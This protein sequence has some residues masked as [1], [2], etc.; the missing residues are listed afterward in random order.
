MNM[1]QILVLTIVTLWN[2]AK[3]FAFP[4]NGDEANSPL[5]IQESG[6]DLPN[7]LVSPSKSAPPASSFGRA[8]TPNETKKESDGKGIQKYLDISVES[9]NTS[10][11]HSDLWATQITE[12]V[13]E[14]AS[15]F[16][17]G[18]NDSTVTTNG[19]RHTFKS[20]T[21]S[22]QASLS[23]P[24]SNAD[25][26][27]DFYGTYSESPVSVAV[28]S[29]SP[30]A[31]ADSSSKFSRDQDKHSTLPGKSANFKKSGNND[32]QRDVFPISETNSSLIKVASGD[33]ISPPDSSLYTASRSEPPTQTSEGDSNELEIS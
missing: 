12:T 33:D 31:N 30:K 19:A 11:V 2:L 24:A 29:L 8:Q 1:Q 7:I 26:S 14:A 6:H 9:E 22:S 16:A 32:S 21:T 25:E 3:I 27:T 23:S 5:S 15:P 17:L 18:Q 28:S 4:T 20:G 10:L 13:D